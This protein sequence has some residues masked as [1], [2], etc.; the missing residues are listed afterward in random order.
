MPDLVKSAPPAACPTAPDLMLYHFPN[1][2]SRVSICA[3]EMAGLDYR[4]Q[5][6]NLAKG[7]Q[8][9]PTYQA[10]SPLGKVPMLIVDGEPLME[11]GAILTLIHTLRP[12]AGVFPRDPSLRLRA[13]GVGGLTFCSATL[14]PI[15]RG[16]ANPS[17]MTSGDGAPVREKS[18]A[19]AAKA[20]GYAESRMAER[21]WWLG[22]LSIVDVYLD[23][24]FSVARRA[25]LDPQAY[26]LLDGLEHR[27]MALPAYV[28]MH[29]V[30][31]RSMAELGL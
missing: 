20:F 2:C 22:N 3:L 31:R 10:I 1:A 5:L 16:I 24:A 4:L 11:N 28:R 25:G 26:P 7:E 27:L 13:E 17:R 23:W 21:G 14:H 15:I 18:L 8:N 30:D 12:D 6:V 9:E 19:L 29:D